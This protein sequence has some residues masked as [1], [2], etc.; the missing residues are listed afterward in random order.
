[1]ALLADYTPRTRRRP[2]GALAAAV[3]AYKN[4]AGSLGLSGRLSSRSRAGGVNASLSSG[5]GAGGQNLGLSSGSD[6][7]SA[8]AS[9]LI[10]KSGQ[11]NPD[12][13]DVVGLVRELQQARQ[14]AQ[15]PASTPAEP[16]QGSSGSPGGTYGPVNW[17]T[18]HGRGI[19]YSGQAFTHDTDGLPGYPA[20]DLFAKPGTPFLAPEDGRI[21]RISGHPGTTSGNVFG[22]SIYFQ[23]RSGRTYFI[24]H[25]GTVAPRGSYRKGRPIGTVSRWTS[26]SP[27]AHVGVRG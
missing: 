16:S 25:L 5:A 2:Q 12:Y 18:P 14:A 24:T 21:V 11:S 23:G 6:P 4:P 15:A 26:G 19:T 3:A 10:A 7:R 9:A 27:H 22:Q 8:L 1:M 17:V 13:A 20:V